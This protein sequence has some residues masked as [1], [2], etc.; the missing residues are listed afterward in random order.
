[1]TTPSTSAAAPGQ[2]ADHDEVHPVLG[3]LLLLVRIVYT[4][5]LILAFGALIGA[6]VGTG[7]A[8]AIGHLV[9]LV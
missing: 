9:E 2:Q 3:A 7:L 5:A 4:L 6:V 1:M 8:V